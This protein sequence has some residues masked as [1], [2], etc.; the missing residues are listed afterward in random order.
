[1]RGNEPFAVLHEGD[2]LRLMPIVELNLAVAEEED[3]VD[4]LEG[5]SRIVPESRRPIAY[6]V[7]L[8]TALPIV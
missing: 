2:Q 7:T 3:G 4:V 8:K 6:S 5:V 1:M